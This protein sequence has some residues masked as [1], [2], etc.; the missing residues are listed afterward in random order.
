MQHVELPLCGLDVGAR[1]HDLRIREFCRGLGLLDCL[2]GS[3]DPRGEQFVLALSLQMV[4]HCSRAR[5]FELSLSGG[6]VC[7]LQSLLCRQ[8]GNRGVGR[9]DTGLRLLDLGAEGCVVDPRQ[10]VAGVHRL[11]VI[12]RYRDGSP[13]DLGREWREIGR[14]RGIV[15]PLWTRTAD[16]AVPVDNDNSCENTREQ[17]R[18][19]PWRMHLKAA[20]TGPGRYF[21]VTLTRSIRPFAHTALRWISTRR[22]DFKPQGWA[23]QPK[24]QS[25]PDRAMSD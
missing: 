22:S 19:Q 25:G 24:S 18:Q 3:D 1:L 17:Q 12:H 16:P 5:T 8:I 21:V 14:R 15:R 2:L 6:D 11:E 23:G 10:N 13:R 20:N 9:R 7:R 4:A